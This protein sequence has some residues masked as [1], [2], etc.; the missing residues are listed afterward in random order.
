MVVA[1]RRD[2]WE[3]HHILRLNGREG[4]SAIRWQSR[5]NRRQKTICATRWRMSHARRWQWLAQ[6]MDMG[7]AI[8][9]SRASRGL[10]SVDANGVRL[11]VQE[12]SEIGDE[13]GDDSDA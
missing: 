13:K 5:T 10:A 11:D 6:A 8:A 3:L 12:I 4:S 1:K 9:R 2:T 7:F